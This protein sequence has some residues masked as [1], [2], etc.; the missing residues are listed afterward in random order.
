MKLLVMQLSP[1][2]VWSQIFRC[3]LKVTR[4][5]LRQY[6]SLFSVILPVT[7]YYPQEEDVKYLGLHLA[8]RLTWNE[9]I[10]AKRKR[11]GIILT[12]MYWLLGR[13]SELSTSN[14]LLIYNTIFKPIR[15]YGIQLQGTAQNI[16]IL[17]SFQSKALRMIMD[18]PWYVPNTVIRK[19]L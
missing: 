8:R 16:E 17:E 1:F 11:L 3:C 4:A 19:D 5:Y 6:H 7:I 10:F 13:K 9:H 14:K 18:E 15:T 2:E 12:K